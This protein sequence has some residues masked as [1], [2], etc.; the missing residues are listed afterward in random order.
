M[1]L[2]ACFDGLLRASYLLSISA[3]LVGRLVSLVSEGISLCL[4]CLRCVFL[5]FFSSRP[6]AS[7][8]CLI[9][10]R[11]RLVPSSR[12]PV[13]S[14]VS[15]G[16]CVGMCCLLDWLPMAFARLVLS[17]SRAGRGAGRSGEVP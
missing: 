9:C 8:A 13:S 1:S 11:T 3:R 4:S 12:R 14:C 15:G 10:P 16:G 6:L 17:S 7:C 5:V 2:A